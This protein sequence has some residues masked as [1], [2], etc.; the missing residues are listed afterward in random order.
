MGIADLS[1]AP[2]HRL[3]GRRHGRVADGPG[4][5]HRP[6]QQPRLS[7]GRRRAGGP[8]GADGDLPDRQPRRQRRH[9]CAGSTPPGAG[10]ARGRVRSIGYPMPRSESHGWFMVTGEQAP[11]MF[12][13]ICGVDL[14]LHALPSAPSPRLRS[15][16]SAPS[17]SAPTSARHPPF[18]CWPTAPRPSTFGPACSMPWRS[19]TAK[20]VGWSA[21]P[22]NWRVAVE[23]DATANRRIRRARASEPRSE[24]SA[25]ACDADAAPKFQ[26]PHGLVGATRRPARSGHRPRGP[27]V[28]QEARHDRG[29]SRQAAPISPPACS[30]RSR[31]A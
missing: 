17:S 24:G 20:P 5:R 26:D 4:P 11:A 21:L 19:S 15:P 23:E 30:R 7:P 1:R 12:A 29:R 22:A 13:K 14:R 2:A 10:A 8:A 28:P 25:R 18:T 31:T 9:S 3:Q 27:R 6:R 16:R